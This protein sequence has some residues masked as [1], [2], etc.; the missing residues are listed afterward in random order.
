M[1]LIHTHTHTH[2][3]THVNEEIQKLSPRDGQISY[4]DDKLI[5]LALEQEFKMAM[6]QKEDMSSNVLIKQ[7]IDNEMVRLDHFINLHNAAIK[8]VDVLK[9]MLQ[10]HKTPVGCTPSN[11]DTHTHT[12]T[13]IY[14]D[15]QEQMAAQH[16]V[17]MPY[18]HTHT[19]THTHTFKRN[20]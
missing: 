10:Q 1:I 6:T 4:M 5:E 18:T 3:H 14:L 12:H 15:N 9:K 2:T 8:E 7:K 13:Y 16:T 19:H 11:L 17:Q 20:S